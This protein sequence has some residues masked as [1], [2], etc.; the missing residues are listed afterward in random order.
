NSE[1][2]LGRFRAAARRRLMKVDRNKF[3]EG[4]R[5]QFGG[6]KQA[7]VD[8]LNQLLTSF[9]NDVFMSDVRWVAYALATTKHETADTFLPIHEYGGRSYFIGR[10]GS[11]TKVGK[12]LGNDTP[13]EGATYAGRGD[14]Q[15]TGESNYERAE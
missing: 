14:V 4:Y 13:E 7:Q 6:L 2:P 9:E 10:Y 1:T 3:F 11:Q 5:N 15:L 8:A 12:R